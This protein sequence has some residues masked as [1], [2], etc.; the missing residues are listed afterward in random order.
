MLHE[1]VEA[2]GPFVLKALAAIACLVAFA[3][4]LAALIGPALI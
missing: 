4:L 2:I 1:F 3:P